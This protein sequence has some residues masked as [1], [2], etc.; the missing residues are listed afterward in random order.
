MYKQFKF[1]AT[2]LLLAVSVSTWA[3]TSTLNFTA[4]CNG[5]GT[6]DDGVVWTVTSDG[7]ESTF[8]NTKGIHYGTGSAQVTYIKLST[9]GISGTIT[10]VVVNA[11]TASGVTAT[12]SVTVGG[13]AFG[14]DPKSLSTTATDYT[15]EG[16]AS[17]A[18]EVTV[19]K[20]SKAAKA[21]YVKSIAVTY[22]TGGGT[23]TVAAPTFSPAA[24]AVAYG[25][26]VTLTQA[27]AYMIN[28]TTD[29]SEPTWDNGVDFATHPITITS[30]VTIKARAYDSDQN[31]SSVVEATYTI[32]RPDAPTFS[33]AAGAVTAGTTVTISGRPTGGKIVYTTDGTDPSYGN[34]GTVFADGDDITINS[35]IT[36]KAIAVDS[37]D[38][39]SAIATAAYTIYDPNAPGTENNPYTVAQAIENTPSSGNVYISGIVSSF[40]NTSIIGDGTNYRYYISDDGTTATQ[41]LVYKGKGLNETTFSNADDLKVGDEVTIYG[42]LTTYQNAPEVASGNYL[43]SWNRPASTNPVINANNVT[44]DYDATSGEIAYTIDNAVSGENLTAAVDANANWISNIAVTS[45]KVTFTTT[46]NEGNAD[47]TATFTLSYTGAQNKTVTVT[48]GHLVVDYATLPF[49]FDGGRADIASTDGLT[50]NG[51]DSDYGSSPK[52]KFNSTDDCVILKINERPGK[53]TFD[54]KGNTFSGGTFKVQ[55]STDGTTYTDLETYTA[56]GD[57]QNEEFDNLGENV[58]YIKWIYTNKVSGNVALGN[59]NLALYVA[60][61][62][63]PV[64]NANDVDIACDDVSGSIDYS[65]SN[66]VQGGVLSASVPANSWITLGT[67]TASE[68]SFTC[69]EN[70]E[71]TARTETVTLTYT[72]NTNET[73]TKDV[74]VT[75]AAYVAPAQPGNWVLTDLADLTASD[76]FVIVGD[77]GNTYALANDATGNSAPSAVAVTVVNNTLSGTIADNLKWNISGNANFGG[78]MFYP[79]GSTSTWLYST[80]QNNGVRVGTGDAKHFTVEGGYLTTTETNEQRYL[81]IYNS[82]DWRTYTNTTGNITGQTFS[83]YKLAVDAPANVTVT[84]TDAG[85]ATFCSEYALDFTGKSVYAYKAS[86]AGNNISF[87]RVYQIPART[88]VLLRNPQGGAASVE[89]PVISSADAITGN[90]FVGTLTTINPLTATSGSFTNYIL[91]NGTEGLGFYQAN[92]NIVGAGKA[93]L[94]VPGEAKTFIAFEE[95]GEAT[96]INNVNRETMTHNGC[97]NLNGQ[98]VENPTKG[99]YIV[100]GKKVVLK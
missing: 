4:K 22:S 71:T 32:L 98:R 19:T 16:S 56:L 75:Q 88:G 90:A 36:I 13:N 73:V 18:I 72:Y 53:L 70:S 85:M 9:S 54:I 79:N 64:I 39:E 47:R 44:L 33:P 5:S 48:Q 45:D 80:N 52:L 51:L 50:Q 67:V 81:G 62:N 66:E 40:Y 63:D 2:L 20:P 86:V 42:S 26:S 14:G 15:F 10:K 93:F 58:R 65:V 25:T 76:V 31:A 94:Q 55:T 7:T 41:L 12:A 43:V 60:P 59:I 100:N 68:V 89:V 1:L 69:S 78:Y 3:E 95:E 87:N 83:F 38:F 77:N 84:V 8:D 27:S 17:G 34:N 96:G 57:T 23:T 97:Y 24:G 46:A 6:A 11:S 21:L 37:H 28:Y 35:A 29:G 92:D 99:L 49:S 30:D 61:S 82:Q 74:T 91:F